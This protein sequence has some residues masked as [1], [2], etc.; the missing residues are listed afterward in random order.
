[1]RAAAVLLAVHHHSQPSA[2][3]RAHGAATRAERRSG[4]RRGP[5]GAAGAANPRRGGRRRAPASVHL[6]RGAA[7]APYSAPRA[8]RVSPFGAR[9]F[10]WFCVPAQV[11]PSSG[12]CTSSVLKKP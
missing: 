11:A 1:M 2:A 10:A 8:S 12:Q 5:P 7:R 6:R 4:G 9:G 3:S